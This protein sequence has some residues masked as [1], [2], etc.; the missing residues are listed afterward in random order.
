MFRVCQGGSK[1]SLQKEEQQLPW[2]VPKTQSRQQH[3]L[4]WSGLLHRHLLQEISKRLE[5][6]SAAAP[7]LPQVSLQS[8]ARAVG[9]LLEPGSGWEAWGEGAAGQTAL[10]A[11]SGNAQREAAFLG[12]MLLLFSWLCSSHRK[13]LLWVGDTHSDNSPGCSCE[14][15]RTI[16]PRGWKLSVFRLGK[17]GK[18]LP[19]PPQPFLLWAAHN[20]SYSCWQMPIGLFQGQSC[21]LCGAPS[22]LLI[23]Q[24]PP[25]TGSREQ[26]QPQKY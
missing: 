6:R 16:C 18:E 11:C 24:E 21:L 2:C 8:L 20:P 25:S 7:A 3:P 17:G 14:P 22:C 19:W 5:N 10:C 13:T 26:Q 12:K 15:S 1:S 23:P 9:A 4:S